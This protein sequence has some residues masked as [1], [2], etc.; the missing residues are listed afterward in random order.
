MSLTSGFINMRM[1]LCIH[2][3]LVADTRLDDFNPERDVASAR[4]ASDAKESTL[5]PTLWCVCDLICLVQKSRLVSDICPGDKN[6]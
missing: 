3:R 1:W 2:K 4:S 5:T 6:L